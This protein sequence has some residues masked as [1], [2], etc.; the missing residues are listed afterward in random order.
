MSEFGDYIGIPLE[1]YILCILDQFFLWKNPNFQLFIGQYL[2]S[3]TSVI[4]DVWATFYFRPI[5]LTPGRNGSQE[6]AF[7]TSASGDF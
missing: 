1:P 3:P 2:D 4:L 7:S 6:P 5:D